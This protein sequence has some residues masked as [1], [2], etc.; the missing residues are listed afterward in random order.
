MRFSLCNNVS[1]LP[2]KQVFWQGGVAEELLWFVSGCTNANE[3]CKKGIHIWDANDSRK[4]LDKQG[5]FDM[6]I[7]QVCFI[8]QQIAVSV[9]W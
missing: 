3:L 7:E 5:N 9:R 8:Y 6:K 1:P 4:F 2:T